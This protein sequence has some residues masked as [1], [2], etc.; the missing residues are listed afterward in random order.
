MKGRRTTARMVAEVYR[1]LLAHHG[2]QGWWPSDGPFETIVGA[3]LTQNTAWTNV[4]RALAN[5]RA[6]DAMTPSAIRALPDEELAALAIEKLRKRGEREEKDLRET[7]ERQRD[8]VR[9]ELAKHDRE[10]QQLTLDFDDEDKRQLESNMRSWR[11]RLEQFDRDLER[12]PQR[13]REFYEVRAKR[14]EPVGLVYL[15]PE[16]N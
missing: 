4:E 13:I 12:E 10:F 8:R 7:L 16:T 6:A 5:L 11:T 9:E 14:I 15:W 3:I 1:R 2:P